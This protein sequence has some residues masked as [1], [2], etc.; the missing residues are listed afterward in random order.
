[1]IIFKKLPR[2]LF[3]E[4]ESKHTGHYPDFSYTGYHHFTDIRTGTVLHVQLPGHCG[5]P[6]ISLHQYP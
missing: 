6:G 1:M 2:E 5:F 4:Q 3:N